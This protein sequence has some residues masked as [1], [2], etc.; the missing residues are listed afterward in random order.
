MRVVKTS[1][2]IKE[3]RKRRKYEEKE[4]EPKPGGSSW[5]PTEIPMLTRHEK[6]GM[7]VGY[8]S[9]SDRASRCHVTA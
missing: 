7:E 5:I 1:R 3:L 9:G 8:Q 2:V 6:V 4:Q